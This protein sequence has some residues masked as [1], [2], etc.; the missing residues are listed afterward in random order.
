M[1][2]IYN[3]LI[4]LYLLGVWLAA[5]FKPKARQ[6]LTGRKHVFRGLESFSKAKGEVIWL[7]CASLGEFEQGRP[8]I[9]AFKKGHPHYRILLTFFSP[10][11]YEIRKN[12]ALADHV[13][14][15]PADTP[16]NARRFLELVN[17]AKVIFVKYEYWHNYISQI[18]G[19]NIPFYI[20]SANF[21]PDQY[22]FRWYGKWFLENLKKTNRFFV[23]S[24]NSAELL[25]SHGITQVTVTGD[26]R[27]DRVASI[28]AEP[29]S[30]PLISRFVEEALHVMVAGSTWPADEVIIARFFRMYKGSF[31]L[32]I[33]PHEINE[34]HLKEME[35][36]FE[37]KAIRY[38]V[39][40]EKNIEGKK[41][42]IIDSIGLLAKIYRYGNYAYV[43]GGFGAGL[44]N[45]VE[46]AVYGMPVLIGP[47]YTRFREAVDL[48]DR[49]GAFSI[50]CYPTF[51]GVLMRLMREEEERQ[52]SGA[53][54]RSFVA[55]SIGAT[56][57]VMEWLK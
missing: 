19:R 48:V 41:V 7:H 34:A 51:A 43:G 16:S 21:R 17:P 13:C 5:F 47:K 24:E 54:S 14:Y 23:Q 38:S 2:I 35:P 28:A 8:L 39:A 30:L 40:N 50:N 42:L 27:F 15:L 25:V 56:A 20:L 29:V 45:I 33:A 37:D 36:L 44:H 32:I 31:K 53:I 10:S 55:Q 26:T 12:Y 4:R 9:E 57:K 22:F 49:G 52:R 3:G 11:G 6:W 1:Q 46:A 18:T